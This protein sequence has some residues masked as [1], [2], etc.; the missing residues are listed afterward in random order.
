MHK[1]SQLPELIMV[2]GVIGIVTKAAYQ[3]SYNILR[4]ILQYLLKMKKS[5]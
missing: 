2:E 1:R 5:M 3:I 4:A